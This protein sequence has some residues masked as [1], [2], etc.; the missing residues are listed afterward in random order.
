MFWRETYFR[1]DTVDSKMVGSIDDYAKSYSRV[2]VR[3]SVD[4]MRSWSHVRQI[5]VMGEAGTELFFYGG[6]NPP[7]ELESGRIVLPIIYLSKADP[8][9]MTARFLISDD[10]GGTWSSGPRD[11]EVDAP[12]GAM[13]PNV[14]ETASNE[15]LCLYRTKAGCRFASRSADSGENWSTPEPT[16]I[17]TPESI[18]AMIK[19][20]SGSLLLVRNPVSTPHSWPRYPLCASL[21]KDGGTTWSNDV[22]IMDESGRNQLSNFGLHELDD[23][24][25]ILAISHYHATQPTISDIDIA[26]FD[27]TWVRSQ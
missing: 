3:E 23:G 10:A 15:L 4:E 1:G 6:P 24:S 11:V 25:V 12:R 13:E 5:D 19:L 2:C 22:V 21:S 14:V 26:L 20:D 8:Q 9:T 7:L 16:R 18:S 27:E 17:S